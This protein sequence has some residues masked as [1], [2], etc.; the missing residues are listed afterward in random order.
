MPE[1]KKKKSSGMSYASGVRAMMKKQGQSEG[2]SLA[3]KI[4][5]GGR[6]DQMKSDRLKKQAKKR[7]K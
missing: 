1:V 3:E 4:N 2:A 7:K 5:F 6:G